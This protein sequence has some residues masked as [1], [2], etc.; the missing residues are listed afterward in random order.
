MEE[1]IEIFRAT[2]GDSARLDLAS[3]LVNLAYM[4]QNA[5]DI[6]SAVATMRESVAIRRALLDSEHPSLLN[7]IGNL[8]ELLLWRGELDAADTLLREV[9]EIRRRIYPAGHPQIGA[10]VGVYARLLEAKGDLDGAEQ[11]YREALASS[12]NALGRRSISTAQGLNNLALFFHFR[13]GDL[14]AAER[15]Y[16][17]A[18]SIFAE[19]RG[20]T[21]PW[22]AVVESNL[23]TA[24]YPLGRLPEAEVLFRH[25]INALEASYPPQAQIL[26]RP[27]L[28]YGVVLTRLGNT[29]GA[30][31]LLRRALEIERASGDAARQARAEAALG[32]CLLAGGR[33]LGAAQLLRRA[34]STLTG[35][36]VPD[37]F[38]LWTI[39]AL[40]RLYTQEGNAAEAA[41]YRARLDT[42]SA[43]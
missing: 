10:T 34:D 6:A 31:P 40:V 7:S 24:V 12:Q 1:A 11:A 29:D 3:A 4:D 42:A 13:R 19:V 22:T 18:L 9:L 32:M 26:G 15:L 21:D 27:L 20:P 39:D 16:R 41:R 17:E 43:P 8:G 28:H 38:L 36:G 30:E 5:G 2:P 33:L 35:I 25:S 23:A 14:P 37:P